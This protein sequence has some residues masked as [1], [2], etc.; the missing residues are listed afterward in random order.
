[1]LCYMINNYKPQPNMYY[2]KKAFSFPVFA[3]CIILLSLQFTSCTKPTKN[4]T[5]TLTFQPDNNPYEVH[6]AAYNSGGDLSDPHTS[7]LDA[8]A[9]T[10]DGNP[11]TVRG[12]FRMD[13]RS[14][15][16]NAKI[17]SAKL[18]LYSNPTPLNGDLVHANYGSNNAMLIN[19]VTSAWDSTVKFANQPSVDNTSAISIPST[20]QPFLDLKDIDVTSMV[21]KMVSGKNYGF[22]IRL[23]N[24]IYYNS[25]IFASSKHKDASKHP[26]LVV[27]FGF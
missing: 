22:M 14:I 23:G 25:R 18:T 2:M 26:K 15:P 10:R 17:Q 19:R 16:P 6:L 3:L 13:L 24:E 4:E 11:V 7:D 1:M 12:L 8:V 9:W 21:Q 5:V 20:T 27:T